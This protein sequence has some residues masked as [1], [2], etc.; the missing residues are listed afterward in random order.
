MAFT[1]SLSFKE[2]LTQDASGSIV[3][4]GSGS[5]GRTNVFAIDGGSGRLFSVD[6]DLSDSLFSVNTIAGLPV[7]EAFANNTVNIGKY[8][9]YSFVAT[10]SGDA[11]IGSGSVMFVSASGVVGI[12]VTNP[13]YKL[14]VNTTD[15]SANVIGVTNGTQVLTLGVNNSSGGS[16]LFENSNS[17]LRFGTNGTEQMR[18]TSAGDVGIGNTVPNR[19]LELSVGSGTAGGLR[20]NYA[21]SA[22]SEGMDITYL[23]TGNTVTSFDS[24]YNSNSAVMQFRMKTAA[25]AVTAMTILGSGNVGIGVTNPSSKFHVKG[26]ATDNVGLALFQNDY[27]SG[28]VYFPA[29]SFINTRGNHSFGIVAEFRLNTA[30]DADRPSILFYSQQVAASWQIGQVTSGWGGNDNFGIGYRASNDPTTFAAWPTN[31]FTITTDGKV[32]IGTTSPGSRLQVGDAG[33][34]PTGL[35]TLTLTGPNTAPE[36]ATKPGLYHRHAVGL[37][38][39]SDYAMS[40]QVNGASSLADAMYITNAGLVGIGTTNPSYKLHVEDTNPRILVKATSTGYA[41]NYLQNDGGTLQTFLDNSTGGGFGF[42]NYVRGVYST[43]AYDFILTSNATER[44]RITSAVNVGIGNTSPNAPLDITSAT[45]STS[46]IQ[47]W[48]YNSNPSNYR[49]QLN[50]DVSSGLVKYSF[51]L[52]N[53][54]T[55][56]N[57]NLVLDRGSVGIGTISPSSKLHLAGQADL[58]RLQHDNAYI[59]FYNTANSTRT[60]YIQYNAGG[61]AIM[62]G[63]NATGLILGVGSTTRLFINSSGL[64]G[65][66]T[67]SPSFELDV[68]PGVASATLRVGSWAVMENVTTNQAMFGRNVVYATSIGSG[69]RNINT[70]ATSAIRMYDYPTD[71][72]IA[73]HMHASEPAGTNLTSWDSTDIKMIIKNDGNVGIGVTNPGSTLVVQKNTAGG[74]GGELSI[75]N[76]ASPTVGNESALNFGNEA[77]TYGADDGN[78]QIKA[79][80]NNVNGATDAIF[81]NWSGTAFL[82]RMR[83]TSAGL[84]GIGTTNPSEK[85]SIAG[86]IY[87]EG[88]NNHLTLKSTSGNNSYVELHDGTSYGYLIKNTSSSTANNALAGA[89]YTYTDNSKAFQHIYAGTP[90]FTILSGGNVGIGVTNPGAKLQVGSASTSSELLRIGVAYSVANSQRGAITWHDGSGITSKIWSEFDGSTYTKL[91]FGGLYSSPS[92]DQ[93]TFLTIRGNGFV[94]IGNTVPSY[95]LQVEGNVNASVVAAVF[96]TA[97]GGHS[98]YMGYNDGTNRSGIFVENGGGNAS[99]YGLQVGTYFAVRDD[100]RVGIGTTNPS[101][102]LQVVGGV[103][104]TSFTGSLLGNVNGTATTATTATNATNITVT[105]DSTNISRYLTFVGSTSGNNGTLV[106]ADL[107][108]NPSTD[109]LSINNMWVWKGKSN[110]ANSD[111]VF[112]GSG[113]GANLGAWSSGTADRNTGLGHFTGNALTTGRANMMFGFGAGQL[114]T[115]GNFNVFIGQQAG[116]LSTT[117]TGNCALGSLSYYAFQNASSNYNT[118]IGYLALRG[119]VASS[120]SNTAAYN[121]AIGNEAGITTTSGNYNTM[122]GSYAGDLITTGGGNTLIGSGSGE[123]ITTGTHNTLVGKYAG[124]TTLTSTVVLSD[125][126]GNIKFHATGSRTTISGSLAIGGIAASAT[127]GRFDASNDIVAYSTSDI[128]LKENIQP[129]ENA[130]YKVNQISGNTFDWKSDPELTIL[131][132]FKGKDIGIIAQEIESI[133][134]EVVTTRDS[135]YKAVKYEKLVPLLIEAIKE[136]TDKVNKL[137]NK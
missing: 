30:G 72:S 23:N 118:A 54:G 75:V 3:L 106:N 137:E 71:P 89:L 29:A 55:A 4:F 42:G 117:N 110:T 116:L 11:R 37:G 68:S 34:A 45:T 25:T 98:I 1:S 62:M 101:N 88:A 104:A 91:N 66:A 105:A 6:D 83:I 63:E 134:P 24:I 95:K 32:G 60:G 49:L 90:L 126:L 44:M 58:L 94:G 123:S 108:F 93:G 86:N 133:L 8:G 77:S 82:E 103:T 33:A 35:A 80:L 85:L 2:T 59:S 12:G 67:T 69:W 20:I 97:V 46:A 40:F 38:V 28:D 111:N 74:R 65:I 7:I 128:R 64:V 122:V 124:T 61:N 107:L 5:T 109:L 113:S 100:G 39:F 135:G 102:T 96:N 76:Y 130:L 26:D 56:Y 120:G 51:D 18:I 127:V 92:Y 125:G 19:K 22:T 114:L 121:V 81:S 129:I 21:A 13:S 48:S 70:G 136:L 50:T 10:G 73:F 53:A 15:T 9:A 79:Y 99:S 52:L 31:Y 36:I 41:I 47:Q 132:G 112:I 119:T 27:A 78:F 131:H 43:G 84:V 115:T 57:N 17:A 16:F 14:H 87:A